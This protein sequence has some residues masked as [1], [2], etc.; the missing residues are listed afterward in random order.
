MDLGLPIQST[1]VDAARSS[2]LD[3]TSI[4]R[5]QANGEAHEAAHEMEKLFASMLVGELRKALPE[6]LFGDGAGHDTYAAW[7]DEH[8]GAA[9]AD[10]GALDLAGQIKASLRTSNP[11]SGSPS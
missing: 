1:A 4:Q 11:G 10:S 7:F 2:A 3:T 5:L 6:G 9:L 8:L